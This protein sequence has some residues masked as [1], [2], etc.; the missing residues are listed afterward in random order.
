MRHVYAR[1]AIM[2]ESDAVVHAT[3][4]AVQR[5]YGLFDFLRV[6]DGVPLYL[7][8]HLQRFHRSA[9]EMHMASGFGHPDQSEA[10]AGIIREL[11]RLNA[12]RDG[13]VRIILTGG[14]SADGYTLGEPELTIL[15]PAVPRP[16][17][18][19]V[20]PGWT[21]RS[22]AHQRQLP[23][24]KSI[25]YLMAVWLQPWLKAQGGD[26]LLYHHEGMVTECPRSNIFI[27]TRQGGL[28]TPVRGMLHGVTRS[29]VLTVARGMGMQVEE[30]DVSL[31]EV[32]SAAE[33]FITSSTKR[34]MP[35]RQVD[36]HVMPEIA[37]GSGS[38][39]ERLW[40]GLA[41]METDH[42]RRMNWNL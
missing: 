32:R 1:H 10:L 39:V 28:A 22:A 16:P 15:M 27:V 19:P 41:A 40:D 34:L 30:R 29:K 18:R 17:D 35:I 20:F 6:T 11:I 2:P 13:G 8:D 12:M 14:P 5:G 7:D 21:L 42:I 3:D 26:D 9:K 36:E 23:H 4:L 31:D 25:D 33:V 38:V 24:V 37:A